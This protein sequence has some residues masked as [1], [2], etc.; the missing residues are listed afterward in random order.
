M[1]REEEK[2]KKLN[3]LEHRILKIKNL[4]HE[5][6]KLLTE[7]MA[8]KIKIAKQQNFEFVNKAGKWLA[9]RL[10][11]ERLKNLIYKLRNENQMNTWTRKR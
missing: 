11:K 3:D 9:Y 5:I 6:N 2:A 4:Q 7:E 10:R 8:L 1:K